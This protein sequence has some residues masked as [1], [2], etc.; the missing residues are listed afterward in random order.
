MRAV[1]LTELTSNKLCAVLVKSV[2]LNCH[3]TVTKI[4]LA[5]LTGFP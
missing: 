2:R 3:T 4:A 5:Q 1:N